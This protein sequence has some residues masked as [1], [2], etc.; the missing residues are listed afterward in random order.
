MGNLFIAVCCVLL[1][2]TVSILA[3]NGKCIEGDHHKRSPTAETSEF[4]TCHAFKNSSCCTADFTVEL[5]ANETRNLYNHSWHLCGQLSTKCQQFWVTQVSLIA[6][7][8]PS[9]A[10]ARIIHVH[11]LQA[12]VGL[13]LLSIGW[14]NYITTFIELASSALSPTARRGVFNNLARCTFSSMH[15]VSTGKRCHHC[16]VYRSKAPYTGRAAETTVI[17]G[18]NQFYPFSDV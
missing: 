4:K 12:I 16:Y 7:I 2:Q 6:Y 1:L 11:P 10:S 15:F 3:S 5:V 14:H 9:P 18:F 17:F 8:A 13:K